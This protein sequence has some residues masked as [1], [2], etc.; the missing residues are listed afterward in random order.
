MKLT[1]RYE[2]LPKRHSLNTAVV[3]DHFGVD[4]EQGQHVVA[5]GVELDVRPGDVVL[6]VGPSGSGK[7]SLLRATAKELA[8]D[9]GEAGVVWID[10]L[11]LP[12]V[13]V[14][15]GLGLPAAEGMG[16]LTACGLGE[17]QLMLRAPS[18]L[19]DGQRYRYRLALAL[20]RRPGWVVADEFCANLDRVLAKVVAFNVRRLADKRVE[21]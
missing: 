21:S 11:A 14:V 12:E 10:R 1:V 17:A 5:E 8:G 6:F 3:M 4:F 15:D 13:P 7:S 20:A 16:L 2:F 19:S 9:A 18:E